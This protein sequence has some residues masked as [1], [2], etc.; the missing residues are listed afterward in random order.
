MPTREGP[1]RCTS[2]GPRRVLQDGRCAEC[3]RGQYYD[4]SLRRCAACDPS[5]AACSGPGPYS[6]SAC[7]APLQLHKRRHQCVPCCEQQQQAQ[8]AQQDAPTCCRCR[9]DALQG[10]CPDV[11]SAGKRRIAEAAAAVPWSSPA[12]GRAGGAGSPG[13]LLGGPGPGPQL[14]QVSDWRLLAQGGAQA[15]ADDPLARARSNL[16]QPNIS[17]TTTT[18]TLAVAVA[19]LLVLIV[20]ILVAML[21]DLSE[22]C[23]PPKFALPVHREKGLIPHHAIRT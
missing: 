15:G 23:N 18:A 9:T 1:A 21:Q 12:L 6:C 2:C 3:V 7:G 16:H 11:S 13:S 20:G 19:A 4:A 8:Q 22:D 17:L 5:C 10:V 14:A